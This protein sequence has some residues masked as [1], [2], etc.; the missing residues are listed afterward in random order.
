[1]LLG[2][3]LKSK[4]RPRKGIQGKRSLTNVSGL[5][6]EHQFGSDCRPKSL[7][8]KCFCGI[9]SVQVRAWRYFVDPAVLSTCGY[10]AHDG[11][12][13]MTILTLLSSGNWLEGQQQKEG[14]DKPEL[15]TK[16]SVKTCM[17]PITMS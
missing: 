7:D 12:E 15:H 14:C 5:F 13:N 2:R 3:I 17:R 10:K 4:P 1:M 16:G 9:P 11:K 6:K 8:F